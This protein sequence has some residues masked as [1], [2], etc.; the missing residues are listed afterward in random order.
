FN[1]LRL[2]IDTKNHSSMEVLKYI[3][4]TQPSLK[5]LLYF[6]SKERFENAEFKIDD[7]NRLGVDKHFI[8][9]L[10]QASLVEYINGG[11]EATR[12]KDIKY[13]NTVPEEKEISVD[14]SKFT[15][16]KLSEYSNGN[17]GVFD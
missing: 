3:K 6:K 7:L 9:P 17:I 5:V 13:E 4:L 16:I 2:D 8:S 10:S 15:R 1:F 12:W 11:I 14:D